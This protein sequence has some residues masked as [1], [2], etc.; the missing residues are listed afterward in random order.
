[1]HGFTQ[2]KRTHGVA[3]STR[4]SER[5]FFCQTRV[6]RASGSGGDSLATRRNAAFKKPRPQP[7]CSDT[8]IL[9]NARHSSVRQ[10]RFPRRHQLH[11]DVTGLIRHSSVSGTPQVSR[12]QGNASPPHVVVVV[13]VARTN[14]P[15]RGSTGREQHRAQP[16]RPASARR[17]VARHTPRFAER[18]T[19][20]TSVPL[21]PGPRLDGR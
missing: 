17:L 8:S 7:L 18:S 15:Q 21:Q 20:S 6:F 3:A 10:T 13:V 4:D 19:E 5:L 9:T 14:R 1:M 12:T 11:T 16:G 2:L